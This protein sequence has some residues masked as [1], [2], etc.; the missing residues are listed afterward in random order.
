[1]EVLVAVRQGLDQGLSLAEAAR[2]AG[3]PPMKEEPSSLAEGHFDMRPH[4][5]L[6][7][8]PVTR[9]PLLPGVTIEVEGRESLSDIK[10]ALIRVL[11]SHE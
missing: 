6:S 11:M 9:Y 1:L 7:G 4:S 10:D 3:A 2:A 5:R 8:V